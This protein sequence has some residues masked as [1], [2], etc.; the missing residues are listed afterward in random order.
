[1]SKDYVQPELKR[2]P[3]RVGGIKGALCVRGG[4]PRWLKGSQRPA[5]NPMAG[6]REFATEHELV[7]GPSRL[8]DAGRFVCGYTFAVEIK[9]EWRM[10]R[11]RFFK[12]RRE[13]CEQVSKNMRCT[14]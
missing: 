11:A 7:N 9:V 14:F 4:K 8:I 10:S 13:G 3:I 5:P 1:M 2:S 12:A 6:L